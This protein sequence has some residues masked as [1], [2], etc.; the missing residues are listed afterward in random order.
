MTFEAGGLEGAQHVEHDPVGDGEQEGAAG[1]RGGEEGEAFGVE[2]GAAVGGDAHVLGVDAAVQGSGGGQQSMPGQARAVHGLLALVAGARLQGVQD[3]GQ[4]VAAGVEG[5]GGQESALLGEEEEDAAHHDGDNRLVDFPG[6]GS[7]R[8]A[9]RLSAHIVA[10][11]TLSTRRGLAL[12]GIEEGVGQGGDD[13]LDCAAHLGAQGLGDLLRR[14]DRFFEEPVQALR[15][16]AAHQAAHAQ[17]LAESVAGGRFL[18][19]G[20]AVDDAG[21]RAP[22]PR[23][24][25]HGPPAPV[26]DHADRAGGARGSQHRGHPVDGARGPAVLAHLPQG[27]RRVGHQGQGP[28]LLPAQERPGRGDRHRLDAIGGGAVGLRERRAVLRRRP[29]TAPAHDLGEHRPHP[30]VPGPAVGGQ[31]RLGVPVRVPGVPGAVQGGLGGTQHLAVLAA[32]PRYALRVEAGEDG[33]G[34]EGALGVHQAQPRPVLL[35]GA[36]ST[37]GTVVS[38]AG[39]SGSP[40][41][42]T[43]PG[44]ALRCG[45]SRAHDCLP[46]VSASSSVTARTRATEET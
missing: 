44:T 19:P 35:G 2:Q 40:A 16:G 45:C 8:I 12:G 28:D 38:A 14:Q 11:S 37:R 41:S 20:L 31:G 25:H 39:A 33:H 32:H 36:A 18:H 43:A 23:G 17:E 30:G 13:E 21:G 3:R 27:V 5:V 9:V 15:R 34:E 4:A 22:L 29:E 7:Q 46:Q 26:R 10:L 1:I 24:T 42:G 6:L